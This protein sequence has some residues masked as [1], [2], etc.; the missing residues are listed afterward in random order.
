MMAVYDDQIGFQDRF[1]TAIL[2]FAHTLHLSLEHPETS[3]N[4]TG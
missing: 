1:I 2:E 3:G 4:K